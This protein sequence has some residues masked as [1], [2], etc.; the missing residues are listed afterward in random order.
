M[1][2][3]VIEISDNVRERTDL[4]AL[5]ERTHAAALTTGVFPIGGLRTRIEERTAYRIADGNP[6]NAFVHVTMRIGAGRDEATKRAAAQAVFDVVCAALAP[7][8]AASP[9]AISLELQEIDPALSFKHNNLHEY[10]KRERSHA[11]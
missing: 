8:F 9:L 3:I 1:A 11:G 7:A 10:V 6:D 2:H 5:L 4:D